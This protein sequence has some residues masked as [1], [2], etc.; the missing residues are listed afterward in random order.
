MGSGLTRDR[1]RRRGPEDLLDRSKFGP[2]P[3][4]VRKQQIH[5]LSPFMAVTTEHDSQRAPSPSAHQDDASGLGL[6][7]LTPPPPLLSHAASMVIDLAAK[8]SIASD[9]AEVPAGG[10]VCARAGQ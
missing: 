2:D 3:R 9:S 8:G 5:H 7:G 10:L 6:Y 4:A 1:K